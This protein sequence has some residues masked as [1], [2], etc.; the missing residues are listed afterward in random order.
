MPAALYLGLAPEAPP[1]RAGEVTPMA[2][3]PSPVEVRDRGVR[4]AGPGAAGDAATAE[5][6]AGVAAGP[7]G[8]MAGGRLLLAGGRLDLNHATLEDLVGLPG[9]GPG[10]G[11]NIIASRPFAA[12]GELRRVPG[13]GARRAAALAPLCQVRRP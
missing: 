4:C 7:V 8:R 5:V 9:I 2:P 6:L 13:L 1:P 10:L 3:C 12:V 11:A